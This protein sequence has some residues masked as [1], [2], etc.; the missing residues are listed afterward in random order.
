MVEE[1]EPLAGEPDKVVQVEE[2]EQPVPELEQAESRASPVMESRNQKKAERMRH[3]DRE[4]IRQYMQKQKR[5]RKEKLLLG[6]QQTGYVCHH[7]RAN[8]VKRSDMGLPDKPRVVINKRKPETTRPAANKWPEQDWGPYDKPNFVDILTSPTAAQQ[9]QKGEKKKQQRPDTASREKSIQTEPVPN[10]KVDEATQVT[11]RS[12]MDDDDDSA[13]WLHTVPTTTG[14]A[15]QSSQATVENLRTNFSSTESTSR[16]RLLP[17]DRLVPV[18]TTQPKPKPVTN[19]LRKIEDLEFY[20]GNLLE[21]PTFHSL[22]TPAVHP[23]EVERPRD[24]APSYRPSVPTVDKE[25]PSLSS[26]R[27]PPPPPPAHT[28]TVPDGPKRVAQSVPPPTPPPRVSSSGRHHQQLLDTT[29]TTEYHPLPDHLAEFLRLEKP[30]RDGSSGNRQTAAGPSKKFDS[31]N[32][33]HQPDRRAKYMMEEAELSSLFQLSRPAEVVAARLVESRPPPQ[34]PPPVRQEEPQTYF[35]DF[36]EILQMDLTTNPLTERSNSWKR[37]ASRPARSSATDGFPLPAPAPYTI[38]SALSDELKATMNR[39]PRRAADNSSD[40]DFQSRLS[41]SDISVPDAVDKTAPAGTATTTTASAA[42]SAT[43]S[44][45]EMQPPKN[46]SGSRTVHEAGSRMTCNPPAERLISARNSADPP[47]KSNLSTDA[48]QIE[49]DTTAYVTLTPQYTSFDLTPSLAMPLD[50]TSI[51]DGTVHPAEKEDNDR[52]MFSAKLSPIPRAVSPLSLI[53]DS[54]PSIRTE[55][56]QSTSS[57]DR[58]ERDRSIGEK[59]LDE[60]NSRLKTPS[61]RLVQLQPGGGGSAEGAKKSDELLARLRAEIQRDESLYRSLQHVDRLEDSATKE[62]SNRFRIQIDSKTKNFL[63][64]QTDALRAIAQQVQTTGLAPNSSAYLQGSQAAMEV[65]RVQGRK[66]LD[67]VRQT[68]TSDFEEA[69]VRSSPEVPTEMAATESVAKS[70][71]RPSTDLGSDSERGGLESSVLS[72]ASVLPPKAV[73][74]LLQ[75]EA[76]QQRLLLKLREKAQ[77][78]KTLAELELLQMQK[79]ILRAQGE[80][81]KAASIKK[82]Q[83]GLLLK[84]QEERAR[85]EALRRQHKKEEQRGKSASE[86]HHYD[87]SSWETDWSA[88]SNSTAAADTSTSAREV[89]IADQPEDDESST[90][91]LQPISEA[92]Q[93]CVCTQPISSAFSPLI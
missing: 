75:E 2:G 27:P 76:K 5:E 63:E 51:A 37:V 79:R 60:S 23:A 77:V 68:Y 26:F 70:S 22:K 57:S 16:S 39:I 44:R 83:R 17:H 33:E 31:Q 42:P 35:R 46:G 91:T 69:S 66:A 3:Y 8:P 73:D 13:D 65:D 14:R 28:R 18:V 30:S 92:I 56:K 52:S 29:A 80:R 40:S 50:S 47:K 24:I 34:Q 38:L 59:I 32:P 58:S 12:Q 84:L 49:L 62:S 93:V 53:S 72:D 1:E 71:R 85:I 54:E 43:C 61:P 25:V 88:A 78:E 86:S 74:V 41:V 36:N 81:D 15:A 82:K 90:S 89:S 87:S 67:S 9:R 55:R 7:N 64:A 19:L 45:N 10:Q 48:S 6:S 11:A 21:A 20:I 4:E